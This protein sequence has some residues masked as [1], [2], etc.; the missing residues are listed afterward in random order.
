MAARKAAKAAKKTDSAVAP[1]TTESVAPQN[2]EG[3]L[4]AIDLKAEK[5][6]TAGKTDSQQAVKKYHEGKFQTHDPVTGLARDK[7]LPEA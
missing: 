4:P 6:K 5:E 3:P 7:P 2:D 1:L